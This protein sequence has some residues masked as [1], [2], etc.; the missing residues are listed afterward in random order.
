M[1]MA[2]TMCLP[3]IFI[4]RITVSS[5]GGMVMLT[6]QSPFVREVGSQPTFESTAVVCMTEARARDVIATIQRHLDGSG[7]SRSTIST[8]P[9]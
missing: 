5:G 1:A 4:D 3:P 6:F 2:E 9:N 8:P 7:V